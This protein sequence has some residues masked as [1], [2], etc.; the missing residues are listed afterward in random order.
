MMQTHRASLLVEMKDGVEFY[1]RTITESH[2][3]STTFTI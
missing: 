2:I 3:G 1:I